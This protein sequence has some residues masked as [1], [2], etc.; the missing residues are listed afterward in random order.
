[1]DYAAGDGDC[2][3]STPHGQKANDDHDTDG[4]RPEHVRSAP[5]HKVC[6]SALNS[7]A[8]RSA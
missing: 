8:R 6:E 5:P 3:S 1:M 2:H 7:H 4:A